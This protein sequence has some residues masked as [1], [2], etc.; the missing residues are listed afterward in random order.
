MAID[1]QPRALAALRQGARICSIGLTVEGE[2]KLSYVESFDMEG[3]RNF[4]CWRYHDICRE[5][6]FL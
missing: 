3:R 4:A 6:W 5:G 2:A 1:D